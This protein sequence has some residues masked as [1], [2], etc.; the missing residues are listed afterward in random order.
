MFAKI[1]RYRNLPELI[2]TDG[3]GRSIRTKDLRP[4][5]DAPAVLLHSLA[6]SDRLD[7]L[8]Y[9]YYR[10]PRK[11]WRIADANPDFPN[12]LA[13]LGQAATVTEKFPLRN[14]PPEAEALVQADLRGRPGV[15]DVVREESAEPVP[16]V[17]LVSGHPVGI[18]AE[19]RAARLVIAYNRFAIDRFALMDRIEAHGFDRVPPEPVGRVGKPV[20][21]PR[22]G[23][24]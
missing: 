14:G 9:K 16:R 20:N 3:P 10:Q 18:F 23:A 8:A 4:L 11:W 13:L 5:P 24:G 22:D 12:P 1:S 21:I 19:E 15:A 17:V 7:H 6:D 2:G